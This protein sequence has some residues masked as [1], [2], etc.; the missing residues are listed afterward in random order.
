[1]P[2]RGEREAYAAGEKHGRVAALGWLLVGAVSG[3]VS[4]LAV[5]FAVFW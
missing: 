3:F 1:M 5:G 4:A 2:R